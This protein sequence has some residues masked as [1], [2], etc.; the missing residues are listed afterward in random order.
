[1]EM[2]M[3]ASKAGKDA[4]QADK[5]LAEAAATEGAE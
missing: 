1:M 2:A 5:N 4:S 3:A